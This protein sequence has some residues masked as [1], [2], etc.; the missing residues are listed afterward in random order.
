MHCYR[1]IGHI[2]AI[3][4]PQSIRSRSKTDIIPES[5]ICI[6]LLR[7]LK[8]NSL[9]LS[10]SLEACFAIAEAALSSTDLAERM[11]TLGVQEALLTV[12]KIHA[13]IVFKKD[14]SSSMQ[15]VDYRDQVFCMM[16]CRAL[17]SLLRALGPNLFSPTQGGNESVMSK[18][19]LASVLLTL[20]STEGASAALDGT[21]CMALSALI[22]IPS[23][24]THTSSTP[25]L[26]TLLTTTTSES[27]E[28]IIL[29]KISTSIL[30]KY[31]A[32]GDWFSFSLQQAAH[33]IAFSKSNNGTDSSAVATAAAGGIAYWFSI[34]LFR[35]LSP[36]R[37]TSFVDPLL[38]LQLELRYVRT[39]SLFNI[40]L[41][42]Y[43]VFTFSRTEYNSVLVQNQYLS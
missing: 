15:S 11:C 23:S 34:L 21:V 28:S 26:S 29:E 13:P 12:L 3:Q 16:W 18:S 33:S 25:L 39:F 31:L 4:T 38:S 9:S 35:L 5:D 27:F 41:F 7:S 40:Y 24:T 2:L 37:I 6:S 10:A 1:A 8:Y 32:Y 22:C 36:S 19:S 14:S 20:A 42:T 17:F 43:S 30:Q